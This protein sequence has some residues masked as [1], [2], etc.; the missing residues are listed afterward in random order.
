MAVALTTS[1]SRGAQ[2][3]SSG[4]DATLDNVVCKRESLIGSWLQKRRICITR[5][6][7]QNLQ[8]KTRDGVSQFQKEA[9]QGVDRGG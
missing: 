7:W 4:S 6:E 8:D 3:G 5:R 9:T 1:P 2:Q